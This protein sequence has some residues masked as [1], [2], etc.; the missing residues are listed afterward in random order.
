MDCPTCNNELATEQGVRI[1]HTRVHDEPLP[2][3]ECK[4]CDSRFYDSQSRRKYCDDCNPN[5]GE[6]SVNWTGNSTYTMSA[7][8]GS[9]TSR[10]RHTLSITS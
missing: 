3:R 7:R 6:E 1:H 8:F 10:R 9:S 2:N 4:G 5:A